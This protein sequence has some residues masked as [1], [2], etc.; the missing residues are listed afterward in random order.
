M[1]AE[2][3]HLVPAGGM[4]QLWQGW[5]QGVCMGFDAAGCD[6]KADVGNQEARGSA[7]ARAANCDIAGWA[8]AAVCV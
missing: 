1:V 7:A 3:Q 5:E 8:R 2:I 6:G 4:R